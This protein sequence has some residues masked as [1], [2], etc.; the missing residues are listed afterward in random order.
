MESEVMSVSTTSDT[1]SDHDGR[2]Y[3]HA[4]DLTAPVPSP[5]QVEAR[6]LADGLRQLADM[7]AANP[8]LLPFVRYGLGDGGIVCTTS[9]ADDEAA[10]LRQLVRAA[11]RVGGAVTKGVRGKYFDL[12]LRFGPVKV[13]FIADR[14][15]VCER[16]VTGTREVTEEVPDPEMLAAVPKTTVTRTEEVVEWKCRPLL[17]EDTTGGSR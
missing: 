11:L 4:E 16:V 3:E 8:E 13:Q 6:E 2:L 12:F 17:G 1:T 7:I 5:E 14:D 9:R 15:D 10:A